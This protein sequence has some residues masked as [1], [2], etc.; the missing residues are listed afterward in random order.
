MDPMGNII[1][2]GLPNGYPNYNSGY[3]EGL[4]GTPN[5]AW[6]AANQNINVGGNGVGVPPVNTN[7]NHESS[8]WSWE[9]GNQPRNVGGN[10]DIGI[11]G[12][13][14]GVLKPVETNEVHEENGA[15]QPASNSNDVK[16]DAFPIIIDEC[17][18]L[19]CY[20]NCRI[21]LLGGGKCTQSGCKCYP[22]DGIK[23]PEDNSWFELSESALP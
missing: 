3:G 10:S 9:T 7:T 11:V 22:K 15:N 1:Y 2:S 5:G 17:D 16:E 4:P 8:N 19:V 14:G 6:P 12:E 23:R 18:Q 20:A 13:D 21:S